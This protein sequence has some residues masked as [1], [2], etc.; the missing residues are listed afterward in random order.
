MR[1]SATLISDQG[2]EIPLTFLAG[3]SISSVLG[4]HDLYISK[5]VVNGNAVNVTIRNTSP[6]VTIGY[7]NVIITQDFQTVPMTSYRNNASGYIVFGSMES[8]GLI[9]GN[10]TFNSTTGKIEDSVITCVVTPILTSIIAD[11]KTITG[12]VKFEYD[13][14]TSITS[15]FEIDLSII[16]MNAIMSRNDFS[17]ERNSCPTNAIGSI[18]GVK[19][20]S[21]GN[22]DIYGILPVVIDIT[23]SGIQLSTPGIG[24]T[25]LCTN[26]KNNIP[27]IPGGTEADKNQYIDD[28]LT[29]TEE[30]W[31][32]WPQYNI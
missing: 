3:M 27:P 21:G 19:P 6:D 32:T 2:T 16:D 18:N 25:E 31:K 4:Y 9:Q 17:S 30:E 1:S 7:F 20:T 24:L 26:V 8:L 12:E 23:S 10:H 28:F 22:I 11:G 15:G 13:N 5:I 14:I 29:A